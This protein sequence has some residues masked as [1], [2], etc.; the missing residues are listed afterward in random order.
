MGSFLKAAPSTSGGSGGLGGL[1]AALPSN[2]GGLASEAAAFQ[3]LGLSPDMVAKFIPILTSF[4]QS[5]G[6]ANLASLLSRVLK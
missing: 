2:L 4:V 3:K 1:A 6:G 5:K